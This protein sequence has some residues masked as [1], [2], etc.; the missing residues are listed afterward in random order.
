MKK[1]KLLRILQKN[2]NQIVIQRYENFYP[3]SIR[4]EKVQM[5]DEE[6]EQAKKRV[7]IDL[8]N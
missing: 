8:N 4:I 7:V 3:I 6:D 2:K 5:P 1:K